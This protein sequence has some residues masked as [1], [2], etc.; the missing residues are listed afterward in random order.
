M[1]DQKEGF[2]IENKRRTLQSK[3]EVVSVC[4]N[5]GE[6]VFHRAILLLGQTYYVK[7]ILKQHFHFY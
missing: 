1:A 2:K 3:E 7:I 5:T 6:L 4:K